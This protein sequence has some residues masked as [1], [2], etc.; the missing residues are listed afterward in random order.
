MGAADARIWHSRVP[1]WE[2]ITKLLKEGAEYLLQRILP[3]QDRL[4]RLE[5]YVRP[6]IA[7]PQHPYYEIGE[8]W[9]EDGPLSLV[10]LWLT[11]AILRRATNQFYISGRI[12]LPFALL[13]NPFFSVPV[14]LTGMF[15]C[16]LLLVWCFRIIRVVGLLIGGTWRAPKG[17]YWSWLKAKVARIAA[18]SHGAFTVHPGDY[19]STGSGEISLNKHVALIFSAKPLSERTRMNLDALNKY[20]LLALS[21]AFLLWLSWPWTVYVD[22]EHNLWVAAGMFLVGLLLMSFITTM[23]VVTLLIR[24]TWR[25]PKGEHWSWLKTGGIVHGKL[26]LRQY[27]GG[28]LSGVLVLWAIWPWTAYVSGLG[29]VL[30]AAVSAVAALLLFFSKVA[31]LGAGYRKTPTLTISFLLA[32]AV[33]RCWLGLE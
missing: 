1:I 29:L 14:L 20:L 30:W 9:W 23:L 5:S 6:G 21:G 15:M 33:V 3:I 31:A 24:G 27:M 32:S 17:G 13:W 18:F 2:Q 11:T 28:I 26:A 4:K 16:V 25:A 22:G 19:I 10:F 7:V 8:R 12:T